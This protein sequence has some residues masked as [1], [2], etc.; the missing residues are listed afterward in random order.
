MRRITKPEI[1]KLHKFTRKHYVEYYDLQTELVD[2]LANGMEARWEVNPHLGFDENLQLE[3]KKFG[4]FGF[5]D[6]VGKRRVAMEKKYFKL[7]WEEMLSELSKT[8]SLFFLLL[9]TGIAVYLQQFENG[10]RLL[11][12][13]VG[14]IGIIGLVYFMISH[15]SRKKKEKKEG[16]IFLLEVIIEKA[17]GI[18]TGL[19]I[20]YYIFAIL[21]DA[22]VVLN[23]LFVSFILALLVSFTALVVYIALVVLPKKKEEILEKVY[24]ERKMLSSK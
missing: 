4:I 14:G 20:P 7:V 13:I 23:N 22:D 24:P 10:Y 17:A 16:K 21:R 8:K 3:F 5:S 15:F 19:L 2:H 11:S 12:Y 9:L 1:E 18:Q 6:V